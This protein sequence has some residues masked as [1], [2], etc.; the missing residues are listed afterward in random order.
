MRVTRLGRYPVKSFQGE[1]IEAA[2]VDQRGVP[3]DRRWAVIDPASGKALSAKR[4]PRLLDAAAV[5]Q[6][7]GTVVVTLPDGTECTP[8]DPTLEKAV[9]L[10]LGRDV[11]IRH[12]EQHPSTTY[13]MNVSSE[14]ESSPL[15]DIP[16][17]PG[18][19]L[20]F[21]AVH[22][23]TTASLRAIAAERP[24]SVWDIHR[25]RPT[26]LV[27]ADGDNFVEDDWIG[28]SVAIG[29]AG[30]VV[31][32]FMP[33]VRCSMTTRAQPQHGLARDLDIAKTMNRT[34]GGNLGVYCIVASP[35]RVEI[36][37][38]VTVD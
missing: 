33:T 15:V 26:I 27:E 37:Q 6:P 5:T 34:H 31:E 10:W 38:S 29:D 18:T 7:D 4:E 23:I 2:D 32:P 19:F 11:H 3:G 20:D 28:H 9:G 1:T 25:F 24:E 36:G 13:E 16:C 12:A 21:A 14:D 17:P 35:G 30:L 8:D 22:I